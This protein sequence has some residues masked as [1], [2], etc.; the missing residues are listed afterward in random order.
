MKIRIPKPDACSVGF[1]FYY[2]L[3]CSNLGLCGQWIC[4]ICYEAF[5]LHGTA[6]I[7]LRTVNHQWYVNNNMQVLKYTIGLT[8]KRLQIIKIRYEV[9]VMSV[10]CNHTIQ[11]YIAHIFHVRNWL[12]SLPFYINVPKFLIVKF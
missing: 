11:I 5:S 12:I 6:L 3:V 2:D 10:S 1:I 9:L 8:K 4:R 7:K